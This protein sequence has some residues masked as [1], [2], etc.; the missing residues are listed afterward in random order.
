MKRY[1]LAMGFLAG[2]VMPGLIILMFGVRDFARW[3]G[4]TDA[5]PYVA[6]MVLF[7]IGHLALTPRSRRT[8]R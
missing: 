1:I 3:G 6:V 2:V 4:Y 7:V 5:M 8:R